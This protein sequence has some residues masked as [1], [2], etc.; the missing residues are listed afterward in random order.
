MGSLPNP[1][2]P[3]PDGAVDLNFPAPQYENDF[4][5][6][7]GNAATD[8][9]GFDALFEEASVFVA[10]FLDFLAGLD[11]TLDLLGQY[12]AYADIPWE[13]DFS[14]ALG[15]VITQ[16]DPD[17]EQFA[18]DMTANSPPPAGTQPGN[19]SGGGGGGG[20]LPKG[21]AIYTAQLQTAFTGGTGSPVSLNLQIEVD[22]A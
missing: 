9:D 4:A 20:T 14:D 12:L 1:L 3:I 7:V 10:G 19:P 21:A 5:D 16:G 11:I 18:T 22:P 6:I 15:E 17:F 8:S 2:Q 13:Q